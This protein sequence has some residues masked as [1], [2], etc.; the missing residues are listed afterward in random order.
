[1][2]GT[3]TTGPGGIYRCLWYD[4]PAPRNG[5]IPKRRKWCICWPT[6]DQAWLRAHKPW[7]DPPLKIEGVNPSAIRELASLDHIQALS[8]NLSSEVRKE[9]QAAVAKGLKNVGKNLPS[10]LSLA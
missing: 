8:A 9:V 5:P 7:P 3:I 1:M 2:N 6:H 4:P 10:D